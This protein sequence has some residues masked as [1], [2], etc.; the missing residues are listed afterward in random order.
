MI[1]RVYAMVECVDDNIGRVLTELDTLGISRETVVIF[2]TDNGPQQV[3]YNS[4]MLDRKGNT[5]EGGIRVPFFVRWP[6]HL[7]AGRTVDRIAAHIDVA[8]TLL[9]LCGTEKPRHVQLDGLSLVPLLDGEKTDWPDRT[10]YFQWHRGDAPEM[11]RACAAISQH[12]KIVQPAGA[13]KA[14]LLSQP[15]FELYDLSMDPLEMNNVAGDHPEIVARM[16][17]GYESWFREM[18]GSRS[19]DVPP[20]IFLGA[21]Q[22]NEVLF[23]RQDWRGPEAG[24]SSK[25]IGYWF[26]DVRRNGEYRFRLRFAK[27]T[28]PGRAVLLCG[29][30]R[31]QQG[32]AAGETV[33]EFGPVHLSKGKAKLQATLESDYERLGVE[34]V[35]VEFLKEP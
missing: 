5:H 30:V 22:Q 8:P 7:S 31:E 32:V 13:E 23:T 6:G 34:Y 3:R 24:W 12:W 21:P 15:A 27:A 4:G 26:V 1:A 16:R 14:L 28:R 29:T 2:L 25:S 10:L 11:Y 35:E 18:A 17:R 19:F 33:A 9:E 20:R